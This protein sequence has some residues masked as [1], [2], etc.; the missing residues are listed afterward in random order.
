MEK[1]VVVTSLVC[2]DEKLKPKAV[3]CGLLRSRI[4]GACFGGAG[5][6]LVLS[7][8]GNSQWTKGLR[9]CGK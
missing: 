5:L 1:H 7:T 6:R 9:D 4:N 2:A 3:M 8:F